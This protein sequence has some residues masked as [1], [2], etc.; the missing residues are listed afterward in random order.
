MIKLDIKTN[1]KEITASLTGYIG[2]QQIAIVRAL[3]K[4]AVSARAAASQ[5]VRH[6]GYNIKASA[7]KSSFSIRKATGNNLEVILT[8]TGKP[9]GL[10]NYGA[11]QTKRGVS[12]SVKG[13]RKILAHAF[14]ATMKNGHAGVFERIGMAR[15]KGMQGTKIGKRGKALRANLPVRELFGPSIPDAV[16]N[17]IV[18]AAIMKKLKEK[19]PQI[20][21]A[22]LNFIGLRG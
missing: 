22:E 21:E 7:I 12:V 2:N 1:A 15:M 9:I 10:I 16:A 18:Q 20:L 19:F 8:A 17:P 13:S 5:E 14:I 4:T 6:S 11:R 3:N